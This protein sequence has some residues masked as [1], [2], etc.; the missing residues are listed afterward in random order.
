MV[1]CWGSFRSTGNMY[2]ILHWCESAALNCVTLTF[3]P[4]AENEKSLV[5]R[6]HLNKFA[7]DVR[8]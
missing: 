2:F 7:R 1:T 6:H 4:K 5:T 3:R 8:S